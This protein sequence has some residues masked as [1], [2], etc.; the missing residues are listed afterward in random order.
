MSWS[1]SLS[2]RIAIR[3]ANNVRP[4]SRSR[5]WTT[6]RQTHRRP[7]WFYNSTT[8]RVAKL[9][10][11]GSVF[12]LL[13]SLPLL[14]QMEFPTVNLFH[15]G[16]G[17]RED[18]RC[19]KTWRWRLRVEK[20]WKRIDRRLTFEKMRTPW[21][22]YSAL[23]R[24]YEIGPRHRN[25]RVCS[26]VVC[27]K[28]SPVDVHFVLFIVDEI[29]LPI[30]CIWEERKVNVDWSGFYRFYSFFLQDTLHVFLTCQ[31]RQ[32]GQNDQFTISVKNL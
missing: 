24:Q 2:I 11:S 27:Y 15:S 16:G 10:S 7:T 3:S 14:V 4:R 28:Y 5:E 13:A 25:S 17:G 22:N 12:L 20:G 6:T 31:N 19:D 23:F 29:C 26:Y 9:H 32:R 21:R 1:V 18:T 30:L 8:R